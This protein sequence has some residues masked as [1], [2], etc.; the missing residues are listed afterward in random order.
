MNILAFA[1]SLREDSYNRTLIRTAV[2]VAPEE[3]SID[4]FDLTP[5]P[6]F[7]ADVEAEG[8]P[9]PV[10]DFKAA[11]RAAAAL[12]IASPEYNHGVPGVLKNAI[13]WASRKA[14]ADRP[15]IAGKPVAL[16]GAS[17]GRLGTARG[18]LQTRQAL[19]GAGA[20]VMPRPDVFVAGAHE[21]IDDGRV[22]DDDT[23]DRI[24]KL[25][26]ALGEWARRF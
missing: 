12:L 20:I 3:L 17:P 21:V 8:D 25:V 9:A 16:L 10:A 7:N 19:R 2:E 22:T 18:Q 1:G 4:V 13:D 24:A 5:I 15:A 6:L 14:D 23:R 26:T 11:I